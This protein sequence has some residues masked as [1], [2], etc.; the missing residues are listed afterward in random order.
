MLFRSDIWTASAGHDICASDP[1]I[2]GIK[3]SSG[4]IPFHPFA[5]EQKAVA[6]EIEKVLPKGTGA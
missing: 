4:A 1:W 6:A 5:A 2:N 3:E